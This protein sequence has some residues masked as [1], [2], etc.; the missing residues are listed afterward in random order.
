MRSTAPP[1][2]CA[3]RASAPRSSTSR[4]PR[5]RRRCRF[6]ILALSDTGI[7]TS[8]DYERG[9]VKDGRRY[10][11]IL[12]AR[13]G[14]PAQGLSSVSVIAASAFRAGKFATAA[15]LLGAEEGLALIEETPGVEGALITEA[16]EIMASEGM[17][18]LSDLPGSLWSALSPF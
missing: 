15:F 13:T 18:T 4:A 5:D 17:S 16:G 9:F 10:H 11:H 7:A 3:R 2:S 12:D 6:A 1:P 14:W 8:G